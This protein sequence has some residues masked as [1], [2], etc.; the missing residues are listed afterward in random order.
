MQMTDSFTFKSHEAVIDLIIIVTPHV[1]VIYIY[2]TRTLQIL[3][4]KFL[5]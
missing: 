1:S 5:E 2:I 3:C 4:I